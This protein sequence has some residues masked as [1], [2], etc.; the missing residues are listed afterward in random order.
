MK[1]WAII[2]AAAATLV[3]LAIPAHAAR[4][5]DKIWVVGTGSAAKT[6]TTFK[7]GD[8]FSAGWQSKLANP[9]GLAQCWT[10]DGAGNRSGAPFWS[11]WGR[12]Q[13]DGTLGV[14]ELNS[15][16]PSQA[17]PATG[18]VCTVSLVSLQGNKQTITA[19]SEAFDVTA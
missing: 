4:S 8:S 7:Y 15:V 1:K 17:W 3:V 2:A 16:D 18:G 19:T 5:S 10:V 14:F 13:S 12:L 11:A 9:F 6:A